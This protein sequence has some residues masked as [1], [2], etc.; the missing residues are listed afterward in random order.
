MK[1]RF[2]CGMPALS[3]AVGELVYC[4]DKR[5]GQAYARRRKYPKL[6]EHHHQT[7]SITANL[8]RIKPS[9]AYKNDLIRYLWTYQ[10]SEFMERKPAVSW[11]NL[12][13]RLM[14]QMARQ[15]PEIDLRTLNRADIYEQELPCITVR[16]A[17]EAGLLPEVG[18]WEK[19]MAEL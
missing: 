19:L 12:Y 15:R 2:Q 17:V 14:Y 9:E 10:N 5:S 13:L 7:G 3:G 18:Y 1:V 4:W 6:S 11:V 8:H 16:R